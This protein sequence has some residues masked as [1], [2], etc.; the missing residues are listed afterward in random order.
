LKPFRARFPAIALARPVT[1]NRAGFIEGDAMESFQPGIDALGR[2]AVVARIAIGLFLFVVAVL[3]VG[4]GLLLYA[5]L[6]SSGVT[7]FAPTGEGVNV[8]SRL[9]AVVLG[10]AVVLMSLFFLLAAVPVAIWIYRAHANLREAGLGELAYSPGWT[11]GSYF[12]PLVNFVIPFRA[13][14]ELH[15]RSHGEDPWQAHAPV[16][17]VSSWWSCHLAAGLVL[18][19]ATFVALLA[20]IPNLY[21]VQPPGVNTGLFLFS[22]LLLAGSA[23]F[24]FRTIGAVTKAQRQGLHVARADVFA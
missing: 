11:V 5:E 12:V 19:V 21:V 24:L 16:A 8:Y 10:L 20:T 15:N 14:R 13:M 3:I 23:A 2:L 7:M 9:L 17:D 1:H 18:A 22:L 6:S 4:N